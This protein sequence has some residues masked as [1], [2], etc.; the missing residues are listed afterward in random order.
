MTKASYK[1]VKGRTANVLDRLGHKG[2][3]CI[4]RQWILGQKDM[5]IGH[6]GE[7]QNKKRTNPLR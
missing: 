1:K 3:Y 4:S 6:N 7:K 5:S 2:I